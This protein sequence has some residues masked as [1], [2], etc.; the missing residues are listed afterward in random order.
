[1]EDKG[2]KNDIDILFK[3]EKEE[4]DIDVFSAESLAKI[5]YCFRN[6]SKVM[7][8]VKVVYYDETKLKLRYQLFVKDEEYLSYKDFKRLFYIEVDENKYIER[9]KDIGELMGFI[10]DLID[11]VN[12]DYSVKPE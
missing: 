6:V 5:F 9:Y 1:M 10:L 12:Q 8:N 7:N 4:Y 11:K 3:T 2:F